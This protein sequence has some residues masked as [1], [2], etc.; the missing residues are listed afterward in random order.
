MT[1]G[2]YCNRTV[3]ITQMDTS[4]VEAAQLMRQ[5]HVGDLV[6][7]EQQETGAIPV[8]MITDRDLVI[9][10]IAQEVP[11]NSVTVK[12]VMS[13]DIVTVTEDKTLLDSLNLMQG[14]G[15]R[16]L[17]VVNK[18]GVLQGIL[19]ADDAIELIAEA[20][21]NLARLVKYEISHEA[22]VHP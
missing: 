17:P 9:E 22:R 15:I 14:R 2:E 10:I 19:S 11:V 12:D 16:R 21:S 8:G 6:V 5:H 4:I 18:K 20:T 7:V 1:A 3:I 13:T